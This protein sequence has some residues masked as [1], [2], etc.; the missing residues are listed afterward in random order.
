MSVLILTA[1]FVTDISHPKRNE[2][3]VIINVQYTGP[4]AK[5]GYPL[6]LSDFNESWISFIDFRKHTQIWN[7]A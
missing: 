2:R 3:K 6:F 1:T 7:S 5:Q 4:Y